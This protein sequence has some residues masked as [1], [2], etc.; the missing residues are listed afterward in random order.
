MIEGVSSS[1]VDPASTALAKERDRYIAI[2]LKSLQGIATKQEVLRNE[3]LDK[4]TPVIRSEDS[5]QG[6]P[7]SESCSVPLADEI[8]VVASSFAVTNEV[9]EDILNRLEI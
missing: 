8:A 1:N 6:M 3:L 4:L 2:E 5:K 9:F 7:P